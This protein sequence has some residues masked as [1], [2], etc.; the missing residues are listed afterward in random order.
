MYLSI[1]KYAFCQ[2]LTL[3]ISGAHTSRHKTSGLG[4]VEAMR[5]GAG[6]LVSPYEDLMTLMGY[7]REYWGCFWIAKSSGQ[8]NDKK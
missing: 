4:R 1:H 3:V 5:A 7:Q 6:N 8:Q 2:W